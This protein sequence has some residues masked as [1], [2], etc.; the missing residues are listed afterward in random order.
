[1]KICKI[2]KPFKYCFYKSV[3]GQKIVSQRVSKGS[4]L[5]KLAKKENPSIPS[6]GEDGD[7]SEAPKTTESGT[8]TPKRERPKKT[9]SQSVQLT[10]NLLDEGSLDPLDVDWLSLA[11][12]TASRL[13]YIRKDVIGSQS[14]YF[15]ANARGTSRYNKRLFAQRVSAHKAL[16]KSGWVPFAVT[17]T[18]NP[19]R[20]KGNIYSDFI[21]MRMAINATVAKLNSNLSA[22]SVFSIECDSELRPHAHGIVYVSPAK[23]SF[24]AENPQFTERAVYYIK[25]AAKVDSYLGIARV[26]L[27]KNDKWFYYMNKYLKMGIDSIARKRAKDNKLTSLEKSFIACWFFC[28]KTKIRQFTGLN[29][30]SVD[31][32]TSFSDSEQDILRPEINSEYIRINYQLQTAIRE[33]AF[34]TQIL[35]DF[36]KW[37]EYEDPGAFTSYSLAK[38]SFIE[39]SEADFSD[40]DIETHQLLKDV[41]NTIQR[42][43]L[44]EEVS[45]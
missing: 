24:T 3:T 40:G 35:K 41:V 20:P 42:R 45:E 44:A 29:K 16:L 43:E 6:D 23:V 2:I 11:K 28:G 32:D 13:D 7:D 9:D 17:L 33:G 38:E 21:D 8:K 22:K 5:A 1:M 10:Q 25:E 36:V 4:E 37:A 31:S 27:C 39:K 30:V 19:N 26:E 18:L 14:Q 15:L 34:T 12:E